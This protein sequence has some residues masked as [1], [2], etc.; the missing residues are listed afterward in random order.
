MSQPNL[1]YQ[2]AFCIGQHVHIKMIGHQARVTKICIE[3]GDDATPAH[4]TYECAWYANETRHT[5]WM[6]EFELVDLRLAGAP[7]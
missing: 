5:A 3:G 1:S 7:E 6:Q 4:V 2:V